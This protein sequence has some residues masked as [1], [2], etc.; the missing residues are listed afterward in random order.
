LALSALVCLGRRTV[1]GLLAANGNL[2]ADWSADYR[3]FEK[4]RF[5]VEGLFKPVREYVVSQ[6]DDSQPLTVFMDDTRIKKKGRKVY[7]TS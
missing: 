2:F 4:K 1:T 7:G 5:C 6:L 3:L